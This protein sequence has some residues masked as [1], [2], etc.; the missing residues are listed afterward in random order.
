MTAR[1][2]QLGGEY[3]RTAL[4]LYVPPKRKRHYDLPVAVDFFAGAGGFSMGL[5]E[6][7]FH[8]AAAVEVWV[9]AAMTYMTNLARPGVRMHFDTDEREREF[10]IAAAK[11]LGLDVD[12]NGDLL[13]D[14]GKK[15]AALNKHGMSIAGAG[16][17]WI[18]NQPASDRGCEHFF[19]WDIRNL[20]GQTIL[21]ALGLDVGDVALVVGG[22]PCQGYSLA[23]KRNVMDPRNS[24]VFEYARLIAEIRPRTFVM[25]NVVGI[26]S[27]VTAEGIPVLDAFA[28]ALAEGSY[29]EYDALRRSLVARPDAGVGTRAKAKKQDKASRPKK[30]KKPAAAAPDTDLL[31]L[32]EAS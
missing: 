3:E 25:E 1:G 29:G 7:G 8:V 10:A 15:V 19:L 14:Q 21:D 18:R 17:G 6:A 9:D 12:R 2:V 13:P 32:L 5:H 23:G 31:D 27:M 11:Q 24:L 28:L 22:P 30:P 16:S 20:S 26:Q 4:G